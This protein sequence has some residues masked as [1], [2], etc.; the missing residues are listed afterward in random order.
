MLGYSDSNKDGGFLTSGWELYKAER[1]LVEVFARHGVRLRLFHGRGGSV[2]RGGGPSYQAILAQPAGAVQGQIRITEQGEV[3]AAKYANPEIGRRNLEMLVAATLEATLLPR[4][5][6][7]AARGVPRGD[8]RAVGAR[9]PRLP[10]ARLRDA[11]LRALFLGID[12]DQRDRRAQHRQPPGLA[13]EVHRASRTC[14]RSPGCSRWA[15]CRADAAGLVRLRHGGRRLARAQ[16]GTALELLQRDVPR[17]AVLPR[18]CCRT[19]T[20]CWPRP[21]S[22]SPRATR[23]WWPTPQLREAIFPRL[24]AEHGAHGRRTCSPS[25]GTSTCWRRNPLLA[26]SIRNRFPYLDPLNHM[27][28]EL[29]QALPRRRP[30]RS[31]PSAA[32]TSPSTASRRAC[33]TAAESARRALGGT[34]GRRDGSAVAAAAPRGNAGDRAPRASP[35]APA[36]SRGPCR[37]PPRAVRPGCSP[38]CRCRPRAAPADRRRRAAPASAP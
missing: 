21:T 28:V 8:G 38:R 19:W 37:G 15:Q 34:R 20:W 16:P 13:Q 17:L 1:A 35:S 11:G 29:L 24:R 32:S 31:A 33:A 36:G 27:Q 22:P 25:P 2:G 10:R 23:S 9:L 6:R 5:R 3:I 18:R 30:T 26:R 14:A 7:R 12:G 4:A